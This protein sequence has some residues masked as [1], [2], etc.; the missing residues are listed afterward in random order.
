VVHAA[1]EGDGTRMLVVTNGGEV[2]RWTWSS[3]EQVRLPDLQRGKELLVSAQLDSGSGLLLTLDS[4]GTARVQSLDGRLAR[5]L[6]REGQK[7]GDGVQQAM[8]LP[9]R[10]NLKARVLTSFKS[11]AVKLWD[12]E[13][14]RFLVEFET[15]MGSAPSVALSPDGTRCLIATANGLLHVLDAVPYRVRFAEAQLQAEGR[16]ENLGLLYLR[17]ELSGDAASPTWLTD[18][19]R[20]TWRPSLVRAQRPNRP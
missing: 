7:F 6:P 18:P 2:F 5:E 11:G 15:G 17:E 13:T 19:G 3:D 10:L 16:W 8:F 20:D 14:G 4:G 9:Q 1:F 12:A